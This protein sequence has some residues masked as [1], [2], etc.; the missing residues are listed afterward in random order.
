MD[1]G[2]KTSG[3]GFFPC[4][5]VADEYKHTEQVLTSKRYTNAKKN[6]PT[7]VILASCPIIVVIKQKLL[8]KRKVNECRN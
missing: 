7:A 5:D 3:G 4:N 8:G 6:S 2:G 1:L